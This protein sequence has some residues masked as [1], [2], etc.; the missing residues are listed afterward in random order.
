MTTSFVT[1][2]T[3]FVG[4]HLIEALLQKGQQVRALVRSPKKA[5]ALGVEGVEWVPGDLDDV[6]ALRAGAG[7][8]D[9]VYHVAGLVAAGSMAEY[10]AVN[11]DGT[12]RALESARLA[13]ARFVLVSSLAAAGPAPRGRPVNGEATAGPVSNY[14]RSKVA[15]EALV[16]ASD[17][18]WVILRPPAVYGPR[19]TEMLRLFK[20]AAL[21]FAPVFGNGDQELSFVFGPDLAEAIAAAGMSGE[22][23]RQIFYPAHPEIVTS[24][25]VVRSIG[26]A[27]GRT[28]RVIPIPALAGRAILRVTGAAAKLAGRSTLLTPDKGEEFFQAAWTCSPAALERATG[29][30]ARHGLEEGMAATAAWYRESGWL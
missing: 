15:A 3:G 5:E 16:R 14:G 20:A 12:A 29:W 13:G 11:R 17:V 1:G 25:D 26:Q 10:L 19:D 30:Q 24:A 2:G 9:V 7:G 4:S 28:V 21:G 6:N 22:A 8:C 18:P 23:T 27:L